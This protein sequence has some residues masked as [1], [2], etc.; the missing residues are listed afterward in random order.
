MFQPEKEILQY[1]NK[2]EEYKELM[3]EIYN[4]LIQNKTK[5]NKNK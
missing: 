3:L 1:C 2:L 5:Q 4:Y